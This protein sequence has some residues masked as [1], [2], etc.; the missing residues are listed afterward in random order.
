M[1]GEMAGANA[2]ARMEKKKCR[3]IGN[4][5]KNGK[6]TE[7][8]GGRQGKWKDEEAADIVISVG[9]MLMFGSDQL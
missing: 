2:P 1:H 3:E 4:L 6:T 8:Q 5:T 7:D 9:S